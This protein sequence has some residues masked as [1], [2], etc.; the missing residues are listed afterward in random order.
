MLLPRP[1]RAAEAPAPMRIL[2]Y[3]SSH[4][5]VYDAW[6]IREGYGDTVA[7]DL[8]LSGL[9]E[10]RF[11]RILQP[12]WSKRDDL[13]VLDGCGNACAIQAGFFAHAAG[14]A[15]LQTGAVPVDLPGGLQVSGPSL[16][17]V[18]A[19]EQGTAFPSLE[20]GIGSPLPVNFDA[21]AAPVPYEYDPVALWNRLFPTS[22]SDR[23]GSALVRSR[24]PAVLDFASD[25]YDAVIARLP[26]AERAKIELHRDLV[27]DLATRMV[28]LDAIGC[29]APPV[30][31]VPPARDAAEWPGFM[32]ESFVDLAVT[33]LSCD[34]TRVVTL[35][36]DDVPTATVGAP[37][38]DLHDG[39]AHL[40]NLDP[41]SA[42]YMTLHHLFH[43]EQVAR[44]LDRLDAIP[45]GD[46]TLLDHTI[47]V[48]HNEL[49]TGNHQLD[50]IPYVL[51]G[52]SKVLRT[53]RWL[54]SPEVTLMEGW[55]GRERV[56][57][58]HNQVLTTLG[59]AMGLD[60]DHF[61][62]TECVAADGSAIDAT[63]I[64][65]GVLL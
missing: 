35:V 12:L 19:A 15:S 13:L 50:V 3:V 38:G 37:P 45:E 20:L 2:F 7:Y 58:P 64:V 22:A 23:P 26:S 40:V 53:G 34:L 27:S 48:W 33:A 49:A 63:G 54:R 18:I 36:V 61:G 32:T 8:P 62:V 28:L 39:I 9:T 17:Q 43:A 1:G 21:L 24:Q 10:D 56:G 55:L 42:E 30:P 47:V 25:R 4:G 29:A 65:E 59:R 5:T 44:L 41:A 31:G 6:R 46:G 52:G 14:H 11:S 60:L 57:R 16:D 51:G